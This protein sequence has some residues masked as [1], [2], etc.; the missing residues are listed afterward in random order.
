V[1]FEQIFRDDFNDGY[2]D[3]YTRGNGA[4][5]EGSGVLQVTNSGLDAEWLTGAATAPIAYKECFHENGRVLRYE[6]RITSFAYSGNTNLG[7]GIAL[8]S[9]DTLYWYRLMFWEAN[10]YVYVQKGINGTATTLVTTSAVTHPNTT[11]LRFRITWNVDS[12]RIM[13]E[14]SDNDGATGYTLVHTMNVEFTPHYVGL[15]GRENQATNPTF[16]AQFDWLNIDGYSET[17]E[18]GAGGFSDDIEFIDQYGTTPDRHTYPQISP[19]ELLYEDTGGFRDEIE[20]LDQYS[21][22]A[23]RH[24]FPQLKP[25]EMS[26]EDGRAG[27]ADEIAFIDQYNTTHNRHTFP[28]ISPGHTE[29]PKG[30]MFDDTFVEISAGPTWMEGKNDADGYEYLGG[31]QVTDVLKINIVGDSFSQPDAYNHWGAAQDGKFYA[32][33]VEAFSEGYDFGTLAGG[34]RTSAWLFSGQEPMALAD[35]TTVFALTSDDHLRIQGT[36]SAWAN[37]GGAVSSRWRW[38]LL[39]GD[40]D[41]R[42]DFSNYVVNAGSEGESRLAVNAFNQNG[43]QQFYINRDASG[44]YRTARVLNNAYASLGTTGTSDTSGK[45]RITR[46]SGV[47]TGYKWNGSSWDQVGSTL[48]DSRLQGVIMVGMGSSG[49]NNTNTDITYS[50]FAIVSGNVSN[51]AGWYSEDAGSNRGILNSVPDALAVVCTQDSVDLIDVDTSKLW[52]RF[53]KSGNNALHYY[54]SA[55]QRPWRLAWSNGLLMIA[56]GSLPTQS[57]EGGAI[58]IDFTLDEIRIHREA[59]STICGGWVGGNANPIGGIAQRNDNLSYTTD[60]DYWGIQDYRVY[61]VDVLHKDGYEFRAIV[62]SEGVSMF[63][64]RRWYY[65]YDQSSLTNSIS[66]ET[67]RMYWCGLRESDGYLFYMDE[68]TMY[69]V[70]R[71]NWEGAM[72]GGTFTTSINKSLPASATL[73]EYSHAEL[74]DGY[75]YIPTTVGVY[76]SDWPGNWELYYGEAGSGAVHEILP[77]YFRVAAIKTRDNFMVCSIEGA[78]VRALEARDGTGWQVIIVDMNTHSIWAKSVVSQAWI[79]SPTALGV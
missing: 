29:L 8:F 38:Y 3:L 42:V 45:L 25:G 6:T 20:F 71:S 19:G 51:Y 48:N 12:G 68:S 47:L 63:K 66:T 5:T 72:D 77:P 70:S 56:H 16:T 2:V 67:N 50:N 61:D 39:P 4:I 11:P 13:F 32:D 34:F 9:E 57:Q 36:W 64:D 46:V 58:W 27:F 78:P 33:G 55:G 7:A 44:A 52:M 35:G 28:Q 76:R 53:V 14:Y 18:T 65:L 10:D 15:Y 26:N 37:A 62:T 1:T 21:T 74:V 24:T 22:S 40:F 17:F 49:N 59:A 30:G 69:S 73:V 79:T 31:L 41:I 75:V 54:S 60:V 23:N 43:N